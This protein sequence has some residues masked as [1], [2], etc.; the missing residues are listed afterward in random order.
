MA[1]TA[2]KR[3]PC[4]GIPVK[5]KLHEHRV[6]PGIHEAMINEIIIGAREPPAVRLRP[7]QRVVFIMHVCRHLLVFAGSARA[8]CGKCAIGRERRKTAGGNPPAGSEQSRA[9]QNCS[10]TVPEPLRQLRCPPSLIPPRKAFLRRWKGCSVQQ[11]CQSG[12]SVPRQSGSRLSCFS[13]PRSGVPAY[14]CSD[15]AVHG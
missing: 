6:H 13:P 12:G 15:A 7:E 2:G 1:E 3:G 11:R 9:N 10:E 14:C 4:T 8:V 5:K